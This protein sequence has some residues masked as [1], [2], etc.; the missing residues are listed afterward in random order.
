MSRRCNA[1]VERECRRKLTRLTH[2]KRKPPKRQPPL[3]VDGLNARARR[4]D[5]HSFT[6]ADKHKSQRISDQQ[7]IFLKVQMKNA[8]MIVT[9]FAWLVLCMLS[10]SA[11]QKVRCAAEDPADVIPECDWVVRGG[12]MRRT[13]SCRSSQPASAFKFQS[14]PY[15][16]PN[17]P[18]DHPLCSKQYPDPDCPVQCRSYYSASWQSSTI[19]ISGEFILVELT[20]SGYGSPDKT[21]FQVYSAPIVLGFNGSVITSL[22]DWG[23]YNTFTWAGIV[24]PQPFLDRKGRLVWGSAWVQSDDD[25]FTVVV[26]SGYK[27]PPYVWTIEDDYPRKRWFATQPNIV[28]DTVLYTDSHTYPSYSGPPQMRDLSTGKQLFTGQNA[29]VPFA[30]GLEF[31]KIRLPGAPEDMIL[32]TSTSPYSISGFSMDLSRTLLTFRLPWISNGWRLIAI[33]DTVGVLYAWSYGLAGGVDAQVFAVDLSNGAV[34]WNQTYTPNDWDG[35][36][37]MFVIPG[38]GLVTISATISYSPVPKNV[39][40][41]FALKDGATLWT[42]SSVDFAWTGGAVGLSHRKIAIPRLGQ[43]KPYT[44]IVDGVTGK[45]LMQC[46]GLPYAGSGYGYALSLSAVETSDGLTVFLYTTLVY[47]SQSA[48]YIPHLQAVTCQIPWSTIGSTA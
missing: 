24:I 28:G 41:V 20:V 39:V 23:Y 34:M 12:N 46:P 4:A 14:R 7:Q 38:F 15:P 33:D 48:S 9:R 2:F 37:S 8:P 26:P 40:R 17:I 13:L 19:G 42:L 25:Q 18:Y 43:S 11:V 36:E 3:D 16:D 10:V 27:Q 30:N 5:V 31:F 22:T 45:E 29:T 6:P 1:A 32:A 47:D 35:V 21:N 44:S